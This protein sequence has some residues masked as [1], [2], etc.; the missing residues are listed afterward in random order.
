MFR[1]IGIFM[2]GLGA[3]FAIG[4]MTGALVGLFYLVFEYPIPTLSALSVPVIYFIGK[5]AE[6]MAH[7]LQI[8]DKTIHYD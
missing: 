7:P 3:V 2:A 5:I 8:K 6:F 1:H 4:L